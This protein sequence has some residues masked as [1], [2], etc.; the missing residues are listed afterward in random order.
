MKRWFA[1]VLTLALA[2][3][4]ADHVIAAESEVPSCMT[5]CCVDSWRESTA[6]RSLSATSR[7]A[8]APSSL[9]ITTP[10]RSS[11]T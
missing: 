10:G 9:A 7:P 2:V 5:V 6:R 1:I 4:S 11:S 3:I 8:P